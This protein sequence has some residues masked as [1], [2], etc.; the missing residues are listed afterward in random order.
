MA[1]SVSTLQIEEGE[2]KGRKDDSLSL[3]G[4]LNYQG[5]WEGGY[6]MH[7]DDGVF[8]LR[9]GESQRAQAKRAYACR[10]NACAWCP[11]CDGFM[12]Y[13]HPQVSPCES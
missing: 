12:Y 11:M 4:G 3:E 13:C 10:L 5:R 9:L 1:L 2:K 6:M 8:P 7:N